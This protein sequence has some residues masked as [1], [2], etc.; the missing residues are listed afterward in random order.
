MNLS[1]ETIKHLEKKAYLRGLEEA[2]QILWGELSAVVCSHR[3]DKLIEQTY[4]ELGE[5]EP[6]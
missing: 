6:E 2:K 1:E 5:Q 3:L 4:V